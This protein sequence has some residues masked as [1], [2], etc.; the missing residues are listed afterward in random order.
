MNKKSFEGSYGHLHNELLFSYYFQT[1]DVFR[2]ALKSNDEL[3]HVALYDWLFSG[4]MMEKLLE[5]C[6]IYILIY[7]AKV[8]MVCLLPFTCSS[9]VKVVIELA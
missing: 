9:F 7:A 1:S 4:N 8:K 6:K 5:V 2:L 3:F